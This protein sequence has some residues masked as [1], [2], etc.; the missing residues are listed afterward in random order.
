MAD[1][2][3]RI[4]IIGGGFGGLFTALE[5]AGAGAVTL[6]SADDHYLF[7]PMLYEYLSG[8]VEAWHIAPHYRE[9]LDERVH[10]IQG[11]VTGVD[12]QAREVTI[13]GWAERQGY[14]ALV[15]AVGGVTNFAGVEGAAEHA[16]PFRTLVDADV[17]RQRM[18]ETLDRIP[19]DAAP[20]DAQRANTFAIVGAGASGI[21]LA[22]KMADLLHDAFGRRG[23][24]G[25]ARVVVLEMGDQILPGMG[26]DLRAYVEGEL[27]TAHVEVHTQTRVR[28][29]T[30]TSVVFE[31]A[32]AEIELPTAA[33]VWVGGVRASPLI[34]HLQLPK[35]ERGLLRV[36]P[37]LQV[38]DHPDIFSLGDDAHFT[39]A[40]ARLPGTAQLAFQQASLAAANVRA[41]LAGGELRTKYFK[42]LGEALSLGTE[43]GA[44][45]TAG[46]VITGALA[47][48]ARFA[49]YTQ[50]LP[51]WHHRLKV[52]AS[53]FFEGTQPRPLGLRRPGA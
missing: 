47:R 48:Q 2:Q 10:F 38:E 11:T 25:G 51:T 41:L 26:D 40:D 37:T 53:W 29:V 8:E 36:G 15:V 4:L 23:L 19:P 24:Q 46:K 7:K 49:L 12:L 39:E 52:G 45:L 21:E 17:I 43:H 16:L 13:A 35:T 1:K 14:D 28:R 3:A 22:T 34:E 33:V 27:R 31:H 32:G 30:P 18:I 50:R 5:L 42:E 20:Q 44:L 6:V 9:L